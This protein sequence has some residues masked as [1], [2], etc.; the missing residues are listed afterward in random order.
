VH[1]MRVAMRRLRS[2]LATYRPVLDREQTDPVRDELRWLAQQLGD[3]R[4]TEVL[5]E[6]LLERVADE[7]A[8]LVMGR[9]KQAVDGRL[10]TRYRDA[11]ARAVEALDD[12]RYF[13]LLGTLDRLVAAPPLTGA[14]RAA[15]KV[16]PGLLRRD[17]KRLRNRARTALDAEPAERDPALHET[18]KAAKRVRYAAE[19]A[20]GTLGGKADK[21]AKRAKHLQNVLGA[22]Q[23]AAVFR[24]ELRQLAVQAQLDGGNA[25]SYGRLHAL[26]Q[27]RAEQAAAEFAELWAKESSRYPQSWMR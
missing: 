24:P 4:D 18:R 26:E 17:W 2:A 1:K 10:R 27:W 25:F 19:S 9:V 3:A 6:H 5:R 8:E 11:H 22:N 20:A 7:P 23:D 13:R 21:L 14:D 12:E 15:A 16:L